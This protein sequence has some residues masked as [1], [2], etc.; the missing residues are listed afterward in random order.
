M[1]KMQIH[2]EGVSVAHPREI[3]RMFSSIARRYDLANTLLSFGRDGYWRKFAVS[4]LGVKRGDLILDI[5]T[6][7]GK[8][9]EEALSAGAVVVGIDISHEMLRIAK[10][11]LRM[12]LLRQDALKLGFKDESFDG[13][14][15]AFGIRNMAS[16]EEALREMVRV[17]KKGGRVVVLE[18]ALPESPI[19]GR[20]YSLYF[21]HILPR[22]GG[23]IAGNRDAY[24]HLV[25][26]VAGFPK[27]QEIK[28]LMEGLGLKTE[29]RF[30]TFGTVVCY[31]GVK[32]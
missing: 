9:A 15:V 2:L 7:T 23:L 22:L 16:I 14:M 29:L 21:F 28:K 4:S 3:A 19:M 8:L 5:A 17:V 25:N 31:V 30:L 26:S 11:R 32:E 1:H 18:F 13:A 6:G 20:L 12:S 27:P 24:E 10:N